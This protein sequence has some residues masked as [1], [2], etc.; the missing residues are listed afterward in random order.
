MRSWD[1]YCVMYQ[2]GW[3]V[4]RIECCD[5]DPQSTATDSGLFLYDEVYCGYAEPDNLCCYNIHACYDSIESFVN[6]LEEIMYFVNALPR[7][8]LINGADSTWHLPGADRIHEQGRFSALLWSALRNWQVIWQVCLLFTWRDMNLNYWGFLAIYKGWYDFCYIDS[9]CSQTQSLRVLTRATSSIRCFCLQILH[10]AQ[11]SGLGMYL[12]CFK[13][14]SLH[15][16]RCCCTTLRPSTR[17]E[18]YNLS[19]LYLSISL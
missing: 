14:I 19:L 4:W 3:G 5:C 1:V 15:C 10:S 13:F 11:F 8:R 17:Y 12:W 7:S 16:S 9:P 2:T 6:R 18:Q